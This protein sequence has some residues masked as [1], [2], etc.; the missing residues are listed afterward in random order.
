M[1]GVAVVLLAAAAAS[2]S[3]YGGGGFVK[4]KRGPELIKSSRPHEYLALGDLPT[5]WDWRSGM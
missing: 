4:G 5:N 1:K 3:A 2:V